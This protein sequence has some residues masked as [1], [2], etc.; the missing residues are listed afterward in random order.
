MLISSDSQRRLAGKTDHRIYDFDSIVLC[1]VV[2]CS[3]HDPNVSFIASLGPQRS[4]NSDSVHDMIKA[5]I[6]IGL[7]VSE[8]S[9]EAARSARAQDR[10]MGTLLTLSCETA[11]KVSA[12]R[13]PRRQNQLTPAVPY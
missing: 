12:F 7:L 4:N 10:M 11:G 5:I 9:E 1:W 8:Y 6:S 2:A 3:D 13:L